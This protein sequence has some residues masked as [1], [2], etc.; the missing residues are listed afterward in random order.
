MTATVWKYALDAPGVVTTLQMPKGAEALSVGLQYP[1]LCLWARVSPEAEKEDRRF[2]AIG[3]GRF[4]DVEL[5]AFV[6]RVT[7]G[8]FE[9]H[10]FEVADDG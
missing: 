1:D 2:I 10:I 8:R 9:W 3:T 7:Q 4:D 5:G 6:G